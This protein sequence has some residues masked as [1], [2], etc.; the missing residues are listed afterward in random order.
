MDPAQLFKQV[1]DFLVLL[2]I[3]PE[4][5]G[6]GVVLAALLRIARASFRWF[7]PGW[8]YVV[9][10]VFSAVGAAILQDGTLVYGKG[11]LRG[12][13]KDTLSLAFIVLIFQKVAEWAA[14]KWPK[15][16]L[17]QDNAWASPADPPTPLSN[18]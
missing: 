5:L 4:A 13:A 16:G 7:G 9:A 12:L 15:L 6:I 2:G 11:L 10:F 18:P 8:T 1:T 14:H 17:P 3:R